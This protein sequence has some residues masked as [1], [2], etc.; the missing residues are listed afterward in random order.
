MFS[1]QFPNKFRSTV[2]PPTGMSAVWPI[3]STLWGFTLGMSLFFMDDIYL[4]SISLEHHHTTSVQ[5]VG[6]SLSGW[7]E[8]HPDI[9][10][11]AKVKNDLSAPVERFYE[12][13]LRFGTKAMQSVENA[14]TTLSSS[15]VAPPSLKTSLKAVS[16]VNSL[17][18]VIP[19]HSPFPSKVLMMG[20][21][22]MKTAMGSLLQSQF[23]QRGIESIREAQIGTGLSRADVVDWVYKADT[24]LNVHTDID[25]LIVQF[26]G[27]D[28]QTIVNAEHEILARY[29]SD[30]WLKVYLER[31]DSLYQTAQDHNV[32]LVIVGLPIMKSSR[33]DN[34]IH[35]ASQKVFAWAEKHNVPVIPIRSLTADSTGEYQQYLTIDNKP[36]KMRLK[37]GVHLSYQGSKVVSKYIFSSLQEAFQWSAET[38][39]SSVK[40]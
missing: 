8:Q 17:S 37:D 39:P 18:E 25:L 21:S 30:E 1:S 3:V 4:F 33:F 7:L 16:S 15:F 13:D 23:R 19:P 12:R 31:W 40:D 26:I 27:N 20:G 28:C 32:Q 9:Q 6:K 5:S 22:S 10:H 2:V 11:V 36:F 24:I 34:K 38:N 29:G 14:S 35:M